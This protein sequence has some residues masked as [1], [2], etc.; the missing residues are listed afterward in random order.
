MMVRKL[1]L[2]AAAAAMTALPI[3]TH[4][5]PAAARTPAELSG[6][7][8]K[9]V[10]LVWQYILLPIVIGAVIALITGGDDDDPKSP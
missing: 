10:G 4:A 3:A 6:K 2:T 9:I 8:E 7:D 1:A 5:A